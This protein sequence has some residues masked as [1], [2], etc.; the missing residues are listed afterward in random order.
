MKKYRV[1]TF[2]LI[3]SIMFAGQSQTPQPAN[4]NNS[5]LSIILER[6]RSR[7]NLSMGRANFPGAQV[8]FVYVDGETP[9]GKPRYVSGSIAVG[10]SDLQTGTRLKTTDRLL[11]GSIGKTFVAALT[12]LLVQEGKVKLDDKIQRWLGTEPWF[13]KL[14]NAPDLTLRMLLNHSSGIENHT[15][16][17]SFQKQAFKN[18]SRNIRY[19][20][21]L[22]Y[23]LNKKPLFPAGSGYNYS[24]TNYILVGMIVEKVTGR[25]LYDLIEEK[26]LKP[27]KL[28]RTIP[29]NSLTLPEVANGYLEGRPVIVDGKFTV[30]PQWEW[31]GGG[32]ASTAEDLARWGHMLYDGE[33]LSPA[34]LDEMIKSTS[35]GEGAVYGL[36]VMISRSSLGR[37]YGHD[38]EF[39]GY[40]SDLRYYTKYKMT[41]AVMVNS[42]ES[43]GVNQFLATAV[44]DFAQI[45][46]RATASREVSGPDQIKLK[47]LAESWL[48]LIHSNNLDEAWNQLSDRLVT[49][50]TKESWIELMHRF[51][52]QTG[53]FKTRKFVSVMYSD[54]QAETVAIRYESSFSKLRTATETLLLEKQSGEW[55]ISSYS[56]H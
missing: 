33:V 53:E 50:F 26:I 38:G 18:S 22:G 3:L 25:S 56:V 52:A 7:L 5:K 28:D 39:P 30:N 14:P 37:S 55:R 31:A 48:G 34:S 49:R 32:F 10:V 42:D 51:L 1:L 40:L 17:S 54:P 19:E 20:E 43:P 44:D 15:E 11:A 45:I 13:G 41:V 36:G 16:T 24:D 9:E 8:G 12:L 23:V 35:P 21:L 4:Q 29:S 27:N 47:S 2:L 6:M 46:I